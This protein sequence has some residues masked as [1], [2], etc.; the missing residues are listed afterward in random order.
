MGG[1]RIWGD[2]AV[3]MVHLLRPTRSVEFE[4]SGQVLEPVAQVGLSDGHAV[5]LLGQVVFLTGSA[6]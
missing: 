2:R 1:V 5:Q 4:I 3:R 6:G